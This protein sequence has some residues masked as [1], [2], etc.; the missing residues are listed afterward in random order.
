MASGWTLQMPHRVLCEQPRAMWAV[1]HSD[2]LLWLQL[3]AL[4]DSAALVMPGIYIGSII[5]AWNAEVGQSPA[6]VQLTRS[7]CTG[8][9]WARSHGRAGHQ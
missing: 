5:A 7:C 8:F 4:E 9:V 2:Q 3:S 6:D 1:Q